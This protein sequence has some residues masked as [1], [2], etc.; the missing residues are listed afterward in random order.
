NPFL[1]NL[2]AKAARQNTDQLFEQALGLGR[3]GIETSL[4][5]PASQLSAIG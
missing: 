3:F 2:C 4:V 5:S 1:E